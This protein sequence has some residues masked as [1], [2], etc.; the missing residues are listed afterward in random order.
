MTRQRK[1][2]RRDEQA[3]APRL[4]YKASGFAAACILTICLVAS[5]AVAADPTSVGVRVVE[6]TV[7]RVCE[8]SFESHKAYTDPFNDVTLDAVV[9][10]PVGGTQIVPAFW[11][12]GQ[13]RRVRYSSTRPGTYRYQTR[14]SDA[15]NSDLNGVSGT[16][17][18]GP[19]GDGK[20]DSHQI[21]AEWEFWEMKSRGHQIRV[22]K[23]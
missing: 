4:T 9:T 8:I 3:S 13:K 12:G 16:I 6:G 21:R 17:R 5:A 22:E 11:A 15:S 18:L 20:G 19:Y 23:K 7:N 2:N 14:C 10:A 1:K